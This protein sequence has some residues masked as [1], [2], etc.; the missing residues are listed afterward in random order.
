MNYKTVIVHDWLTT[1][2]G[3]E[4]VV[5]QIYKL[6]PSPIYTLVADRKSVD[7]SAFKNAEIHTS[8]IQNLPFSASGYRTYLPLYPMAIESFD[9]T[10]YEVILSQ[11]HSAAK[12]VLKRADQLHICYCNTPMRY[13][14]DVY[15]QYLKDSNLSKGAKAFITKLILHY[16]RIWD[17]I[18]VNRVDFF[19]ANSKFVAN[20]IKR[21]YGR[22]SQVIYPPVDVDLFELCDKKEEYYLAAS[23][24]VSYKKMDVI[25]EAFTGLKYKKLLVVGDGPDFNKIKKLAGRNIEFIGYQPFD[26]LKEYMSKA[27]A[28]VFA[29]YEDFGIMPVEAQ[30]SGTPVIAYGK[31]G[32]RETV[33]D[34]R[35]GLFFNDQSAAAIIKAVNEFESRRDS[36]DPHIARKNSLKFSREK[37]IKDYKRFVDN[38]IGSFFK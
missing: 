20:R 21:T 9:L 2:A 17:I 13:A 23:R 38:A 32:A 8:F 5:E 30:A 15:H 29:A 24:M 11:S 7:N 22:E 18:S 10:D 1:M 33:I 26:K 28:F 19:I 36:F 3:S 34:G 31:G 25:V 4:K 16:I 6:F 35:T 12:G 37:F 14:W 27:K